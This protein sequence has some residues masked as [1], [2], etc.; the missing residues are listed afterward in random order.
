M[1]D[2]AEAARRNAISFEGM[3]TYM[4]QSKGGVM[5]KLLIPHDDCPPELHSDPLGTRYQ[6]AMVALNPDETAT[7]RPDRLMNDRLVASA[8]MLC[9]SGD[10][11]EFLRINGRIPFDADHTRAD[12]ICTKAVR[13][14]CGVES[15]AEIATNEDARQK[16]IKLRDQ[17]TEH[18]L[19]G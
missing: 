8:G 4:A 6:V 15:R 14:I 3:K 7:V 12:D 17:F 16:F 5:V 13:Q 2:E 10:F 19:R 11:F 18:Q 1:S 9:R